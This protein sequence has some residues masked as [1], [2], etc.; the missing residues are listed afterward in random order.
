[1]GNNS[2]IRTIAS[3]IFG[4]IFF[5]ILIGI[6]NIV[7]YSVDNLTFLTIVAF[8]NKNLLFIL[9]ISIIMLLGNIFEIFI[10]P[11]NLVYPLFNAIG[12]VL[13]VEFIFRVLELIDIFTGK[14]ISRI[15]LPFYTVIVIIVFMIIIIVRYVHILYRLGRKNKKIARKGKRIEWQDVEEEFKGAMYNL[16]K[17]LREKSESEKP[18]KKTRK[19]KKK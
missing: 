3:G 7:S 17:N 19:N 6:L 5:L 14:N 15:F 13:W 9:L 11:F 2:F 16:A 12:G 4:I 1:M 8:L 18:K 10:F